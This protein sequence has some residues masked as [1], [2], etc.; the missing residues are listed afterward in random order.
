[1]ASDDQHLY[2]A[3]TGNNFNR[4]DFL[5]IYRVSWASLETE[6]QDVDRLE[7][8]YGDYR[9]GNTLSHNFDSEALAVRG[10]EL[11]LFTKNRGDLRSNLYRFPKVPGNYSPMPSQ[12]LEVN[13]PITAADINPRTGELA[14]IG[15]RR[16]EEDYLWRMPTSEDGVVWEERSLTPFAPIDQWEAVLWDVSAGRILLS[17]EQNA[18]RFAGIAEIQP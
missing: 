18:T 10:D 9:A 16:G 4:R 7:I 17:H 15:N 1:M 8:R 12:S 2:I 6:N 3:D 11:W 5:V 14:L 13:S